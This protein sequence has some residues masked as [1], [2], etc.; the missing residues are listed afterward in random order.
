MGGVCASG[1]VARTEN[2]EALCFGRVFVG[3]RYA[4][5]RQYRAYRVTPSGFPR[6]GRA[7]SQAPP[8]VKR[9]RW[10]MVRALGWLQML[11]AQ[12]GRMAS[13]SAAAL[14]P[15]GFCGTRRSAPIDRS[16]QGIAAVWLDGGATCLQPPPNR[17]RANLVKTN[18]QQVSSENVYSEGAGSPTAELA[19]AF[20]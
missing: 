5:S 17:G 19:N 9:S 11:E 6:L 20:F 7:R 1:E 13:T 18:N 15:T 12:A 16:G 14:C 3:I 2:G 4:R 10:L 8:S